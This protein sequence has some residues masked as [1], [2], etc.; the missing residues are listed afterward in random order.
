MAGAVATAHD[1]AVAGV[2][3]ARRRLALVAAATKLWSL[4]QGASA[5]IRWSSGTLLELADDS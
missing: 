5:E 2:Q 3:S 4:Q 1:P